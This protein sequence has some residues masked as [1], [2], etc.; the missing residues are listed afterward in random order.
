MWPN[1]QETMVWPYLLKKSLIENFIFC[2]VLRYPNDTHDMKN[3][4]YK[5]NHEQ[6]ESTPLTGKMWKSYWEN[7]ILD[8]FFNIDHNFSF[9]DLLGRTK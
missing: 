3:A 5:K 2:A 1:P 4:C 7:A 8:H 9:A 6:A